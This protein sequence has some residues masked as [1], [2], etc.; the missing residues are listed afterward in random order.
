MPYFLGVD[1]GATKTHALV[2]D[3]TG[4]AVGFGRTGPGN[5]QGVG[6]EGLRNALQGAVDQALGGAG[7]AVSQI[8][9]AGFGV[10]G[11]DWP[12]QLPDH[13]AAVAPLALDCPKEVVNDSVIALLAGA[14]EGWG[15]VLIA[16]TG[17]NCRG[18]D[19]SGRE[20][21]T[22]GEGPRFGEFGGASS[23]VERAFQAVAHE[24]TRRGPKTAVSRLFIDLAGARD[25]DD[26]IEGVDLGRYEPEAAWAP[27]VFKAAQRGD[28]TAREVI[29]WSGTEL[30]EMAC[31]VIRQLGIEQL[32]FDVV[33][34]GSLFDGGELLIDPLR[35]TILSVAP[36]ARLVRLTAPPVVGAVVL[37]M[38]SAGLDPKQLRE[39]LL[40]STGEILKTI[41]ATY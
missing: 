17:S 16:G 26:L 33:M 12:A 35:A 28:A 6:Y 20:A 9:G 10:G 30:G 24:W 36:R 7:L 13:L 41:S 4:R 11:Y 27:T 37:A 15:L 31:G 23:L 1:V 8:A 38:L 34:A 32:P 40:A 3:E 19:E 18:R 21:R 29:A 14:S 25:L 39:R 22:T 2:T 5:H